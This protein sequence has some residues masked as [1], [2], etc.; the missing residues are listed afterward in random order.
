MQPL[1]GCGCHCHRV[2]HAAHGAGSV[3]QNIELR[4]LLEVH[5]QVRCKT[6]DPTA[7]VSTGQCRHSLAWG[8]WEAPALARLSA[9]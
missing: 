9:L 2:L 1:P 6:W 4:Y 7:P 8:I 3:A 5:S